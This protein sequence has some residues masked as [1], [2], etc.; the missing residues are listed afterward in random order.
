MTPALSILSFKH[1]TCNSS[2]TGDCLLS[3]NV[4]NVAMRYAPVCLRP[5]N[6]ISTSVAG[7]K[8]SINNT[9]SKLTTRQPR[10]RVLCVTQLSAIIIN[11]DFVTANLLSEIPQTTILRDLATRQ[12]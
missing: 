1:V 7:K 10:Q 3:V 12:I 11:K 8:L 9:E 6:F 2:Y 4:R 5:W